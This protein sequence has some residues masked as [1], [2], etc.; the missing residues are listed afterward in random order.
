MCFFKFEAL[1]RGERWG[2]AAQAAEAAVVAAAVAA[3]AVVMAAAAAAAAAPVAAEAAAATAVVSWRGGCQHVGAPTAAGGR[4]GSV[5]RGAAR[6]G[7]RRL[8]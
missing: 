1:T 6:R 7:G 8:S 4:T 5:P 3:V 2:C